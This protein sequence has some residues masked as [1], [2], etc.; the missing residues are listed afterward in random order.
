M[1]MLSLPNLALFFALLPLSVRAQSSC[2]ASDEIAGNQV[3]TGNLLEWDAKVLRV[4]Q[5]GKGQ[6][7]LLLDF[8]RT[9]TKSFLDDGQKSLDCHSIL[10]SIPKVTSECKHRMEELM[11]KYYPIEIDPH[12][13]KEEKTP[14]MIEWYLKVNQLLEAQNFTVDDVHNAVAECKAFSLRRGVE[15]L[16]RLAITKNIPVII[17]SAGLGNI[18]QEV[19]EQRIWPAT[20]L[21]G[22][23]WQKMRVLSNTLMWDKNGNHTGFSKPLV[24]VYNKSLKDAPRDVMLLLRGRDKVV[25]CGDS[26]GDLTM[27]DGLNASDVVKFG[28]LSEKIE[29]RFPQ[30]KEGFDR[31]ILNDGTFQP[32]IELFER[33]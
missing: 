14:H 5:A 19:V 33:L 9:M 30:Y 2:S 8:D 10:A 18:I 16:L 23:P 27:A 32:V 24:H 13:S 28:F 11:D 26:T 12:M 4:L 21:E 6:V 20:G 1:T 3:V 7:G 17:V 22:S 29:E 25:V 31:V 15:D